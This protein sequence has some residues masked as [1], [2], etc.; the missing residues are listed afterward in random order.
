MKNALI[1]YNGNLNS[2]PRP[3]RLIKLLYDN[4]FNVSVLAYDL[5]NPLPYITSAH[6]INDYSK[7]KGL[8][9]L[10]GTLLS[11]SMPLINFFK[12]NYLIGDLLWEIYYGITK[13]KNE[14]IS[15]SFDLII[16]EDITLVPF[17]FSIKTANSKIFLDAREYYVKEF[18][19]SRYFKYF[20]A[21]EKDRL[22]HKYLSKIDNYYTVSEGIANA[23]FEKFHKRP[24]VVR[25]TPNFVNRKIFL[26]NNSKIKMVHHGVANKDRKLE[27]MLDV[28]KLL[29]DRFS[30]DLYLNGDPEYINFLKNYSEGIE[31]ISFHEPVPFSEINSMLSEYDLGFYLLSPTSFNNEYSLPNKFFEFIQARI[32][33]AIGPSPEMANVVNEFKLGIVSSEFTVEAMA[34]LLNKLDTQKINEMKIAA[35]LAANELCWEKESLKLKQLLLTE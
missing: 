30:F 34:E 27:K 4:N 10:K 13:K 1:A 12:L 15:K 25:S 35:N 20:V 23:Y 17:C 19:N 8:K 29:D 2:A 9:R 26:R 31:N 16:S 33:I 21:P 5:D 18:E 7:I 6:S 3:T 14:L 22:C 24:I 11:R 28:V 32:G